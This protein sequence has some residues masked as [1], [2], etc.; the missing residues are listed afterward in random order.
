MEYLTH[1]MNFLTCQNSAKRNRILIILDNASSHRAENMKSFIEKL[2]VHVAFIST[3]SPEL[4]PV[5]NILLYL[6]TL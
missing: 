5:E 1:L 3:Y 2:E 6:K 4:V